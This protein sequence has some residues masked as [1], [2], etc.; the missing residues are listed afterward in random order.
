MVAAAK[1]G[2]SGVPYA[3][4]VS[5]P[6]PDGPSCYRAGKEPKPGQNS[7][8]ARDAETGHPQA[9]RR[10]RTQRP[11]LQPR[12]L[13][14]CQPGPQPSAIRS[15]RRAAPIPNNVRF[16]TIGPA[17]AN[18][19]TKATKTTTSAPITRIPTPIGDEEATLVEGN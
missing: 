12:R 4:P 17:C 19:V 16:A 6:V 8:C 18:T 3:P 5:H 2:G 15:T 11:Q 13:L 10:S 14:Q 9:G 1:V 7:L